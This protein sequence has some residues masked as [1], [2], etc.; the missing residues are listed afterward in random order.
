MFCIGC[1]H[2]WA[3]LKDT[4]AVCRTTMESIQVLQGNRYIEYIIFPPSVAAPIA[5]AGRVGGLLPE[6]WA[7]LFR[8][9]GDLLWPVL[10]WL[11][12][13]LSQIQGI[14]SWLI[15]VLVDTI[16]GL[17]CQVGLDMAALVQ[18]TR[19]ILGDVT[20]PLM[21]RLISVIVTLCGPEARRLLGL[22]EPNN[23]QQQEDGHEEPDF[24]FQIFEVIVE[25][26]LK[27]SAKEDIRK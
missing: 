11:E 18:R 3:A 20:A 14:G 27:I 13:V 4:C 1:I 23:A 17:L 6:Q 12:A 15:R 8:E 7:A 22:Q 10:P 21:K 5:E 24:L 25:S 9:R 16:Q 2:R 26:V 19:N